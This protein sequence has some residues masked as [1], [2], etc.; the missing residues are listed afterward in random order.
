M[1]DHCI[2]TP[3]TMGSSISRP[4]RPVPPCMGEECGYC[5]NPIPIR[6]PRTQP[7]VQMPAAGQMARP[8]ERNSQQTGLTV[9]GY[10]PQKAEDAYASLAMGYVPKQRWGQ[11]YPP[12]QGLDR[13]TIFP[14]LDR[15]FLTGRCR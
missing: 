9:H 10:Q 13:G 5:S 15:P 11:T 3:R 14:E 6:P 8:A 2:R 1:D 12:A 7:P 4:K